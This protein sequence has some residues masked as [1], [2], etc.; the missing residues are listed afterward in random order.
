MSVSRPRVAARR[1]QFAGSPPPQATKDAI[2]MSPERR[3]TPVALAL[4]VLI[5]I[6]A[7]PWSG[8]PARAADDLSDLA[9]TWTWSWKDP[10]G[11]T[12]QHLLEVE[13]VG[14]KL[15]AREE[16]DGL[17]PVPAREIRL[18]GKS[19]WFTVVRGERRA[20]YHGVFAD[21]NTING[22]VKITAEGETSEFRWAATR[23]PLPKPSPKPSP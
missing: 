14:S 5:P 22:T 13:G 7:A 10:A 23:K 18:D 1:A 15:A 19:V 8:T 4:A 2:P 11:T 9:G 3:P 17:G 21:R 20:D 12:H 16:F 6:F